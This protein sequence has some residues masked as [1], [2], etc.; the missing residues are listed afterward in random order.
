M[1]FIVLAIIILAVFTNS[2]F[3]DGEHAEAKLTLRVVNEQGLAIEN[4]NSG[5][6]FNKMLWWDSKVI[7]VEG[8][9]DSHGNFT[10]SNN[11]SR[12]VHYGADKVGY[13]ESN[14]KY[15]F[16]NIKGGRWEPWNPEVTVVMRKKENPVPMYARDTQIPLPLVIPALGKEI[17]F[18]LIEYD[19]VPPFGKGKM[20]DFIFKADRKYINDRNFEATVTISF[21]NQFDGILQ[22]REDRRYGSI[23]KLPRFSPENGYLPKITIKKTMTPKGLLETKDESMNYFFRV[24]SEEKDGKLIRAMYGKIHGDFRIDPRGNDTSVILFTYY[25]NPDYTRN[26]EFGRNL[27]KGL[28][29]GMD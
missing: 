3:A 8:I 21:P 12:E 1:K 25:L 29:V 23:F 4:A 20:S 22:Y 14:Y 10:A 13:Y 17:G 11:T 6:T 28:N 16:E 27:F 24:R 2:S 5:V 18:D 19:W 15:R 7:P 9:T 26:M